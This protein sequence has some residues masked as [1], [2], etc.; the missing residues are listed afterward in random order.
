M[1]A[2]PVLWQPCIRL[3][4]LRR[5][6]HRLDRIFSGLVQKWRVLSYLFA[7]GYGATTEWYLCRHES[8]GV[9]QNSAPG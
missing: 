2:L 9:V 5:V 6:L 4:F 7:V 1:F 8:G 3:A